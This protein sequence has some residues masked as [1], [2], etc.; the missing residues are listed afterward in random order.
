M[1]KLSV[2]L[3]SGVA[4]A[5]VSCLAAPLA[6]A[7]T[8]VYDVTDVTT[9][10]TCEGSCTGAPA[11]GAITINGSFDYDPTTGNT[12]NQYL[13]VTGSAPFAGTYT[14]AGPERAGYIDPSDGFDFITLD[15][16]FLEDYPTV[17]VD[18]SITSISLLYVE[19][20]GQY[21]TS[22][23]YHSTD[24]LGSTDTTPIPPA[25]P[26]FVA[27]L[28]AMGLLGRRRKRKNAAAIAAA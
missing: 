7:A 21:E 8:V 20:I 19:V 3:F 24:T 9:T 28:G 16:A 15:I 11:G 26:M 25:L 14:Q 13:V 4:I 5:A 22:F 10:L 18:T 23:M 6:N 12:T 1:R 2:M 17:S 27:G